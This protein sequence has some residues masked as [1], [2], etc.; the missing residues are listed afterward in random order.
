M[1]VEVLFATEKHAGYAKKITSSMAN[2][3]KER[4]TGI[5][6]RTPEYIANKMHEGKAVI[7]LKG[8]QLAGFCYIETWGHGKYVAHSGLI[9]LPD[10][11]KS[12]LARKIKETVFELSKKKFPN[13]KIFGIT[14]S[15]AV[16]KINSELGY[17]PVTFSELTTDE[18]FW[19]GCQSCANYDILTR[20]N[21]TLCLCTGMIYDTK[22]EAGKSKNEKKSLAERWAQFKT[23]L[24]S[25]KVKKQELL[26]KEEK[27]LI[28]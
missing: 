17:K 8:T 16:M 26:K 20:T 25:R 24:F 4:G 15:L 6:K 19:K 23:F 22:K 9:V 13:A 10:F 5:A 2:A 3:A 7:A 28:M 1:S 12:G 18:T 27:A 11:R 14:T 21:R